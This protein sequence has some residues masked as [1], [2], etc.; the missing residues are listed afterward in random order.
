[1]KLKEKF[2]FLQLNR[3]TRP[4]LI[5]RRLKR[6][7]IRPSGNCD[8][9]ERCSVKV[10]AV[11]VEAR[12]YSNPL[13]YVEEM[14]RHTGQAAAAG[15]QLLVFPENNSLQLLGLIPGIT[16]IAETLAEDNSPVRAADLFRFAGP[17]IN[18]VALQV[19]SY[20][21]GAYGIYIMSGSFPYPE[22]G[23]VL[24]RAFLFGPDGGQVG[25]Q[26]K[27]HLMPLEHNW[28]LA[29]GRHFNVFSTPLGRLAMPVCMDASYFETF[30]ILVQRGG[31][32][33]VMVP[34]ANAEPYNFWLA[35]R[36]I[37]PR[38]QES[39]VYGI[40]SALVGQLPG[41]TLTGRAGV[42]APL[43]LTP[44][45]DGVISEAPHFDRE[46]LVTAVLDMEALAQLR[47]NHPYLGDS[48]PA[49]VQKYFPSIYGK[50]QLKYHFGK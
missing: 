31:A 35:L 22:A 43:E 37:W 17:V 41:F 4:S 34:I 38:V 12:L 1:M 18:R 10:G 24:N 14:C 27:V 47:K 21:A 13:D 23:A 49:F 44:G 33:I 25:R 3:R 15:V 8:S 32:E 42:F 9:M 5:R 50:N 20:L 39:T 11:Q 16:A 2:L 45:R 30:R 46:A 29:A 7:G 28:G 19:F 48:N 40:K 26:D 6:N 36:G